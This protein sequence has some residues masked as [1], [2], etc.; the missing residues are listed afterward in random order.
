MKITRHARNN[1]R[2]YD[3]EIIDI[4]KTIRFPE[5]VEHEG[6]RTSAYRLFPGK[7]HGHLLKVVYLVEGDDT[8]VITAYPLRRVAKE[9]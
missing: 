5:R 7:Y 9:R 6:K 4:E 2:L 8:I 3:I 1:I